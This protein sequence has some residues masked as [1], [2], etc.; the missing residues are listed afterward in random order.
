MS[1]CRFVV[2]L[3]VILATYASAQDLITVPLKVGDGLEYEVSLVPTAEGVK[4]ITKMFCN[5]RMSDFGITEEN[6]DICIEPVESYLSQ[7]IPQEAKT[8][9]TTE[10]Q[11]LEPDMTLPLKVGDQEFE[12]SIQP[13]ADAAVATAITFCQQHGAKF[14]VTE[15]TFLENCLN[16]VGEYLKSAA[17]AE[18][19]TRAE[20]RRILLEADARAR[21]LALEPD[22]IEVPM[23]IADLAFNIAWN[24]RRSN[25]KDMAIKFC[26]EH[27]D[28]INAG[29]EDCLPPVEEHLTKQ[30]EIQ[31]SQN[32]AA[33]AAN[34]NNAATVAAADEVRIVK[35]KVDIAGE[36][37]EFRFEPS[38]ADALK[39]STDFCADN[40][41]A[42]G[43]AAETIEVQC[44]KPILR[45][46]LNALE[47]VK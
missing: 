3:V 34:E 23:K 6:I 2:V 12:I 41:V 13:N 31:M 11:E 43:V 47:Q 10:Q 9:A 32:A 22:D 29:F 17:E 39:V 45:V 7:Y 16:P 40:G 27:G 25:A 1:L 21:Q 46:L 26:T 15:E 42:L 14:G 36:E 28:M 44:I 20:R 35:A 24:S 4:S 37:F 8:D 5:E 33:A 19:A 18:A 38:E 30:A